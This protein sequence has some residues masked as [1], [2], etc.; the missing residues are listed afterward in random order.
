MDPLFPEDDPELVAQGDKI[1]AVNLVKMGYTDPA[2]LVTQGDTDPPELV[3][4]GDT[5]IK[6]FTNDQP[7]LPPQPPAPTAL[8]AGPPLGFD[9]FWTVYPRQVAKRAAR[10]A[11]DRAV[12]RADP[13]VIIAGATRYRRP[14]L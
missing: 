3:T 13:A 4:Q 7:S 1:N 10:L 2:E 9:D 14:A 5:I 11:W 6:T 8:V 12:K